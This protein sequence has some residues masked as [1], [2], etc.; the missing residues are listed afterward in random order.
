MV[1][2]K[3]GGDA[4]DAT[5]QGHTKKATRQASL[6][7]RR[8]GAEGEVESWLGPEHTR[9]AKYVGRP[10]RRPGSCSTLF[11]R[12]RFVRTTTL[13]TH[14]VRAQ[15]RRPGDIGGCCDDRRLRR[16]ASQK[17]GFWRRES[18]LIR[19][20]ACCA[21]RVPHKR[22]AGPDRTCVRV[23]KRTAHLTVQVE[24]RAVKVTGAAG[25]DTPKRARG[26]KPKAVKTAASSP[27]KAGTRKTAGSR[28]RG[29]GQSGTL[30]VREVK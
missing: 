3:L 25:G 29:G 21:A 1:G 13:A 4:P 7:A 16:T 11:L 10:R 18:K 30:W 26:A 2:H 6:A 23:V 8:R 9:P 5:V 28:A 12:A 27:R 19:G 22:I 14:E 17:K 20:T 15:G 24:E